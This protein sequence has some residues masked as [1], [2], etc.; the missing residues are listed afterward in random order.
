MPSPHWVSLTQSAPT[1]Q[2]DLG[3]VQI[4]DDRALPILS[5]LSIKRVVLAQRA[6]REPQWNVNANQLAYVVRGQV[7]VSMLGDG[8]EFSSFVVNEGQMYHVE[9]GSV[10]HIEN[11]GDA[12]AEI[13]IV[14]R[15][16]RPQHFSLRDSLSAMTNAVLGNTYDLPS[17]A[18]DAFSRPEAAEI[19]ERRGPIS[20]NPTQRLPNA[21]LFDVEAQHAPLSYAYGSAHLARRQ[22]W[23]AL[24]DISMYSLRIKDDGMRD[25]HWHPVTAEMGYVAQ[26]RARM[27]VLDP[28]NTLDEYE[29]GPGDVYFVPRAFPHHIEVLGDEGFH[30]IIFFDQAMPGDIGYRA[31]ATAFSREVLASTY[32]VSESDLPQFPF[33]P[34]DPLIVGRLNRGVNGR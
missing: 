24:D 23:A 30:F 12:E 29:L 18:F 17:S 3:S 19:L 9:S 13:I 16:E 20:A 6:I 27:R 14:L 8:N 11:L 25:A 32:G 5:R 21:H 4:V 26:G 2:N 34:A 1:F 33:T 31:T 28:D 22:Y 15:S 7:L 10:Y